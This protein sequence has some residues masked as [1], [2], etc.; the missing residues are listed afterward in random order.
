[1]T[2]GR[3]GIT[4]TSRIKHDKEGSVQVNCWNKAHFEDQPSAYAGWWHWL[5]AASLR[6]PHRL[7]YS[8]LRIPCGRRC[9][10]VAR[11]TSVHT[12]TAPPRDACTF[13]V[14]FPQSRLCLWHLPQRNTVAYVSRQ[15]HPTV[16]NVLQRSTMNA[17]RSQGY[18]IAMWQPVPWHILHSSGQVL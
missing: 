17:Q 12:R 5:Q 18:L 3:Q 6:Q 13:N 1:M 8:R 10:G 11:T 2:A 15:L 9:T 14:Q 7:A 4:C 16:G